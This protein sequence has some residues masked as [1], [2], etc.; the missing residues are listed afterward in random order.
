MLRA[1]FFTL[2]CKV[3]QYE[4]AA[5]QR[6]F[7]EAGYEIVDVRD[8]AEVYVVNSCTVTS[9]GDKKS[10]QMLRRMRRKNP[11]AVVCLCGCFPQAF[12][13]LA[14]K[15]PE[16]DI[17]MGA[18]NRSRLLSAVSERLGGGGRVIDIAAHAKDE[19][20]ENLIAGKFHSRTRAFIKIED[21]CR[22]F[23]AYCIIPTARGFVRSKPLHE[24]KSELEQLGAEGCAEVVLAGINL[25]CY[26]EDLNLRLI[27][28][29]KLACSI[30]GIGRVRLSS[31]EPEL[32]TSGDI[33]EMAKLKKLCPQFHLSLQS[34]CDATL[35]RMRRQ[36]T[37]EEYGRIAEDLRAA[38]KNPALTTDIMVGF[39][40][41]TDMEF[42]SS[43][44]FC[45]KMGFAK[46]HVFAYSRRPGTLAADMP[47]QIPERQ[48]RE[49]SMAMT[50]ATDDLRRIFLQ[51]Q[52]GKP[53]DV[54]FETRRADGLWEGYS[55]NYTPVLT[56]SEDDL[57]GKII[58]VI[59]SKAENDFCVV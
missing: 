49:R 12:P 39:P 54:L 32:L 6:Q 48:K 37:T 5:L 9:V 56:E 23:C 42:S 29:V 55:G 59:P 38:F 20:F 10:R 52:I 47:G 19:K 34:G 41:E 40:G 24:L 2:G 46:A 36:Y 53:A 3:N 28:A 15:I 14:E 43:L 35:K 44:E 25:S 13:D 16:A 27:D 1:A 8:M 50:E 7:S 4:T 58:T 11:A 30:D 33:S 31:L 22:R 45:R 51:S 26:G 21:G 18:N 17:I 57:N